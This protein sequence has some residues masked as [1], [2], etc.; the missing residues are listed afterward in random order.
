[1]LSKRQTD[2]Q[3]NFTKRVYLS[4]PVKIGTEKKNFEFPRKR[5]Q[6]NNPQST[7]ISLFIRLQRDGQGAGLYEP[8]F[9]ISR[10]WKHRNL[11][12]IRI[13]IVR[14][15][16]NTLELRTIPGLSLPHTYLLHFMAFSPVPI[17]TG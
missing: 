7:D 1:M 15:R 5:N 3:T 11:E 8:L 13:K 4:N 14:K 6:I 16:E 10:D 9:I 17:W 2:R 12:R